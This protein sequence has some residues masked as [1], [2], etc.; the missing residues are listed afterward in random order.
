MQRSRFCRL[1]GFWVAAAVSMI[2]PGG[3]RAAAQSPSPAPGN[4]E[5]T[6]QPAG[7]V[8]ETV[9]L[10]DAS[11]TGRLSVVA[12]GQGQDRVRMTV[13]NLSAHRLN[14]V[15][16]P[17][18]VAVSAAGQRGGG[19]GGMQSIG[20]GMFS[21]RPG[22]FGRFSDS[23]SSDGLRSVTVKDISTEAAITVPAS[24]TVDLVV[25]GVCLNYGLP[26]PTPRDT[27]T[28]MD[29]DAYTPNVRIRKSLR[30]LCLLGT[31]QPV[32]QAVMWRVC[33]DL[34]FD[35]M[36]VQAGK[37]INEFEI[38]LA[39]RFVEVLDAT[40]EGNLVD[41]AML[42]E[43]RVHVRMHGEGPLASEARRLLDQLEGQKLLGL[44]I[45]LASEDEMPSA[46][47]P[48]LL[49][50]VVL[51]ASR[52]G[53]T[54]GRIGVSY[55]AVA[56]QWSPLGKTTFEDAG[57]LS[58][59][60]GKL[61]ARALDRAMAAAFVTVK[62]ARRSVGSTTMRV[63]NHLPFTV[64]SVWLRA[65][66]SAGAPTVPFPGVGIGP[67]RAALLPIQAA[68]ALVERVELNGL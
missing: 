3:F 49:I 38:A 37:L 63:E 39:E 31:S 46:A 25:P 61:L 68:T 14:V 7:V 42:T 40:E 29:V 4:V 9:E 45:S 55:S 50:N 58:L 52:A 1:A 35:S 60:D 59:L 26:A 21:N 8:T 6:S 13:R 51:T 24:E 12:H 2:L 27:F 30:S 28:L 10:L 36:A 34:A 15:L 57:S 33:N 41:A 5:R 43:R 11:K 20:L 56:G 54:R 18:L 32:A 22:T 17:G 44:P 19:G 23:E 53:E 64:A 66:S 67:T 65:G 48:A 16:P 62:H 47:S